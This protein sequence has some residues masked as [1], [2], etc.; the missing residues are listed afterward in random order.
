MNK[1]RIFIAYKKNNIKNNQKYYRNGNINNT[2]K[3]NEV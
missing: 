2:N 3:E 1:V